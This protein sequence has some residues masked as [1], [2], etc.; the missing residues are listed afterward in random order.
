MGYELEGYSWRSEV[1]EERWI[2]YVIIQWYFLFLYIYVWKCWGNLKP[3][4]KDIFRAKA[5]AILNSDGVL[6]GQEFSNDKLPFH[7]V[8]VWNIWF[9]GSCGMKQMHL[10][11]L[12][13]CHCK[14]A[15]FKHD[16]ANIVHPFKMKN[17]VSVPFSCCLFAWAILT[18][19]QLYSNLNNPNNK[20]T[21][22]ARLPCLL[23][24][25][26]GFVLCSNWSS[27]RAGSHL[28]RLLAAVRYVP[29]SAPD[30]CTLNSWGEGKWINYSKSSIQNHET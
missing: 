12:F 2:M 10:N 16:P 8:C 22:I 1:A 7:I 6:S 29:L 15:F 20:K 17:T 5:V 13:V 30:D 9:P 4:S 14:S 3:F 28:P 24:I 11:R 27:A 21:S 25:M 19:V 26:I 23:R 18:S